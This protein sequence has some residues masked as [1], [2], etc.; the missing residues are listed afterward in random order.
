MYSGE[1]DMVNPEKYLQTVMTLVR[2]KGC[3]TRRFLVD[4]FA[5]K[6]SMDR[7]MA[8]EAVKSTVRKLR[9]RG[10]ITL[11]GPGVYCWNVPAAAPAAVQ[12]PAELPE[13]QTITLDLESPG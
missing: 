12:A 6:Y 1:R 11:R 3:V 7:A 13:P 10:I 9:R 5:K 8:G 4:F 2:V